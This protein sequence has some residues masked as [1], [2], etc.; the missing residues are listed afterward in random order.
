MNNPIVLTK[1]RLDQEGSLPIS[2]TYLETGWI[3]ETELLCETRLEAVIVDI[4]VSS[5]WGS[6]LQMKQKLCKTIQYIN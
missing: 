6:E 4:R 3:S 1:K 5:K 2:E